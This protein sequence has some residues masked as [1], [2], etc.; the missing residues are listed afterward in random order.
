VLVSVLVLFVA[1][2]HALASPPEKVIRLRNARIV[3]HGLSAAERQRLDSAPSSGLFLIQFESGLSP[4]ERSLLADLG[5]DLLTYVP[6]DTFIAS[7]NKVPRGQL[8]ALPFVHWLERYKP[9]Y[10]VQRRLRAAASHRASTGDSIEVAILLA[11]HAQPNRVAEVKAILSVRG[12][13]TRLPQG[14][15]LHGVLSASRL[16]QLSASDA[17]LWI[18]TAPEMRLF[19]EEAAKIVGGDDGFRST[20][21]VTQQLGYDG[22]GVAVAVADTGLDSGDP[23]TMHPDLA[24]RVDAFFQYGSLTDASDHH[25]HGTHVAGI[26][27]GNAAVGETDANGALY[28]LGVASGAHVV[29]QRIFDG[30]GQFQPPPSFETLTRDAVNAGAVIGNNSWGEDNQGRYDLTAMEFDELVRDA[31]SLTPGDQPYIL[32]FSAGNAGPVVQSVGTPGVAKNVITTGASQNNRSEYLLY[33]DGQEAM[34][35]FSSRGPCEDGRIKPDVVAPGTWIAS[36]RSVFAD[37][38]YAWEGISARY[39]YEG[40]TSQAGP[41]VSG[42]A[43]V[44][45]QFYR[46]AH[47]GATPSPALVKAALANSSVDMDDDFGTGSVPNNSEGWGRVD[48]TRVI[49]SPR[50]SVFIDQTNLL[51]TGG[52][53]ETTVVVEDYSEPLKITLAYTDVPGFPGAIPALVNDLDL[54]VTGPDGTLYRG[55]RFYNGD[56]I[57][58]PNS[59]DRINNVEG[60][61]LLTPQPGEYHV[62]VFAQNVL[63][64]ARSDSGAVDQDFALVI[65][66]LLLPAEQSVIYM[67]QTAFTAPGEIQVGVVDRDQAGQPSVAASITSDTEPSGEPLTLAAAGGGVFTNTIPAATGAASSDGRLQLSHGDTITATYSDLS[68]GLVRTASALADLLPPLITGVHTT[69]HF[70]RA[71]VGWDTDELA[72]SRV[73]YGTNNVL[74]MAA[75]VPGRTTMHA[76]TLE[77]LISGVTYYYRVISTDAAGNTAT[78]DN[79]GNFFTLVAPHAPPILLVDAYYGGAL[80]YYF[81]PPP[82]I[83][84]YTQPLTELGIPFDYW[85]HSAQG[86]P[87]LQVLSSYRVVIWRVPEF[88]FADLGDPYPSFTPAERVAIADYLNQGGSFF[89]SSMELLSRL[90]DVGA[91]TFRSDV[92]HVVNF[93][94]D[95]TVPSVSGVANDPITDGMSLELDYLTDYYYNDVSDT[96]TPSEEATGIFTEDSSGQFAGLRYPGPGVDAPGRLVLLS[97]PIDAIPD[98]GPNNRAE[99]LRRILQ[100]LSPGITGEAVVSTDRSA[101]SLPAVINVQVGDVDLEGA[102]T[103]TLTAFSTTEPAGTPF[104]LEET[105]PGIFQGQIPLVNATNSPATN[106]LRAV[107]GDTLI[108]R[109]FDST[110]SGNVEATASVDVTPPIISA[111]SSQPGCSTATIY[112]DTDEKCDSLVQFGESLPLPINRTKFSPVLV[113]SHGITLAG[114]E[115]TRDYFYQVV[116]RDAAGNAVVDNNGGSYYTFTTKTPLLPPVADSFEFG[117]TNWSVFSE[118][119]SESEW[120][121][122]E[123]NNGVETTAH[124]PTNA[125]GSMLNGGAL[126]T[127]DTFLVSP[128]IQLIGGNQFTLRFW[129]SYQFTNPKAFDILSGGEVLVVEDDNNQA[130]QLAVYYDNNSG[131]EQETLDL[132]PYLG[133]VVYLVWHH[134]LFTFDYAPRGGWLVDDVEITANS[135]NAGTITIS[136]N[137]SQASFVLTGPATSTGVGTWSVISNAPA[138]N[139]VLSFNPVPYYDAPPAQTN[140]LTEGGLLAFAAAYT[141]TDSNTNG[142]SDAWEQTLFGSVSPIHDGNMDSDSDGASDFA[143]FVAGTDP[144][145]ATS[146]L[147]VSVTPQPNELLR[148]QWPTSPGRSYR[149][150]CSSDM[151]LWEVVTPWTRANGSTLAQLLNRPTAAMM[152]RVQVRP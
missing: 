74:D 17:V 70:G 106:Q 141:F 55:N 124:S 22:S 88:N 35:D 28:G 125:W 49:N 131:W 11:P 71:I 84:N 152:Y 62:R 108:F 75:S 129:H 56:S 95:V 134:Q 80:D 24:G 98:F 82:P 23:A 31:D 102:G 15:I 90:D 145:N 138:G 112:W 63:Q 101:Y 42:A 146:H 46:A 36:L 39:M 135:I 77:H 21:T 9:E 81:F 18:E 45:V 122:G 16:E 104:S 149:L 123:P 6:D 115:P 43:A 12:R 117:A 150:E 33:P 5:V 148:L 8:R 32:E 64:D 119:Y 60:V 2:A 85:D 53:F 65:S 3:T 54:E 67:N 50:T 144:T 29:A 140:E 99:V 41:Q 19:D 20:P 94:A 59:A 93:N 27:A 137:L 78:N 44:F 83:S 100:F 128:A 38:S 130:K 142:I 25:G 133:K 26:V 120:T 4:E 69:N 92:L 109:F 121:L 91:G 37:D 127:V 57:P 10:K 58:N 147:D 118:D 72:T 107:E 86:S 52:S 111:V 73:E 48:L 79:G 143:E 76:I 1:F 105:T 116:S 110:I 7:L 136:N 14:T 30:S 13:E 40:G 51:V 34:A 151:L 87:S 89:V 96:F 61:H 103:V 68:A 97:F 66:G 139:Y 126:G 132:T 114:L 113:T 47:G